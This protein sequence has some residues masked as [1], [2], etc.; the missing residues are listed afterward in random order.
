MKEAT[1]KVNESDRD[2]RGSSRFYTTSN[3]EWKRKYYSI[4]EN[5]KRLGVTSQFSDGK[6]KKK[7][8]ADDEI[9]TR[10]IASIFSIFL[11]FFYLVCHSIKDERVICLNLDSLQQFPILSTRKTANFKFL[12][13]TCVVTMT[14]TLCKET[15]VNRLR[16][17]RNVYRLHWTAGRKRIYRVKKRSIYYLGQHIIQS[18]ARFY[19]GILVLC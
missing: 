16:C 6:K 15:G 1:R 12:H 17:T 9:D 11:S 7:E 5:R 4:R 13:K 19:Y 2:K 3:I 14:R 8:P 18:K 10:S